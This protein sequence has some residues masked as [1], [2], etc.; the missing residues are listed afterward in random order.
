MGNLRNGSQ[1]K[2]DYDRLIERL[3]WAYSGYF[4]TADR[5][6]LQ[7]DFRVK[8]DTI[9]YLCLQIEWHRSRRRETGGVLGSLC[10]LETVQQASLH[11][12]YNRQ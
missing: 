6:C 2:R 12:F 4:L 8:M 3:K 9:C 11:K 5:E 10:S 7:P 1:S